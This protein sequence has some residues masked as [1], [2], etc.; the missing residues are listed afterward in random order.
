VLAG[1]ETT[2]QWHCVTNQQG[3]HSLKSVN[4]LVDALQVASKPMLQSKSLF[5]FVRL[6]KVRVFDQNTH[7]FGF[8]ETI[9]VAQNC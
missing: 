2:L 8:L 1:R 5:M 4:L 7:F 3:S 6:V 9:C